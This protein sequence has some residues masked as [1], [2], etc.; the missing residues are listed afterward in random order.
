[1]FSKDK[2]NESN[3]KILYET[4]PNIIVYSKGI[5]IGMIL[6]GFLFS[7]YTT[8]IQYIG[9]MQVYLIE[10]SKLPMTRYF[11]IAIF[12]CIILVI[13]YIV[14]K[15]LAWTT[16]KYTITETRV[17]AEKGLLLHKKNYMPF[18]TIQDVDRSQS[19][20]GR[21]FSV[22]TITLYSAYDG[23]NIK[24]KDV[25][26]PKKIEDII[27][28]NIRGTHLKSRNL[29][30]EETGYSNSN[31]NPIRPNSD[32]K[33]HYRRMEDLDDLE[34]LDAKER[35]RNL[36]DIRKKAQQSRNNDYNKSNYDDS[37]YEGSDYESDYGSVNTYV[38]NERNRHYTSGAIR[39]SYQRN[40]KK[41]FAN[42]YEEF[43]QSNLEAQNQG[44]QGYASN[45]YSES[46]RG[47]GGSSSRSYED[48][49][50]RGYGGSSSRSYDGSS[51]G[52]AGPSHSYSESSSYGSSRP[53]D[54]SRGNY[55]KSRA[56]DG[57]SSNNHSR[58]APDRNINQGNLGND[59]GYDDHKS[60]GASVVINPSKDKK[61]SRGFNLF[62]NQDRYSDDYISD[63][64]FDSTIN[65]AMNNMEDNIKFKPSTSRKI[66]SVNNHNTNHNYDNM[67]YE[68]YSDDYDYSSSERVH[69]P[70]SERG[71]SPSSERGYSPSSEMGYSPSSE[72]VH[73][74]SSKRGYSPSSERGY[75]PSSERGYSPSSERGYSPSSERGYGEGYYSRRSKTNQRPYQNQESYDRG[76]DNQGSYSDRSYDNQNGHSNRAYNNQ[77]EYN[78]SRRDREPYH[79]SQRPYDSRNARVDSRANEYPHQES[80]YPERNDF[81]S[82][83]HDSRDFESNQYAGDRNRNPNYGN[84]RNNRN[85]RHSNNHKQYSNHSQNDYGSELKNVNNE[86]SVE[87]K[88]FEEENNDKNEDSVFAK[89]SRKFRKH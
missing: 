15:L 53:Y 55:S 75:S 76:Y 30:D 16:V 88:D 4:Q 26:S 43:H 81:D 32:E 29:Y 5:L 89:H 6:L 87:K 74:P 22:G 28:E 67:S 40:P 36:R 61:S 57:P 9:N 44:S 1:M 21:L 56:Y 7:L 78:S 12:V 46:S 50:S 27:F 23:N 52:F 19:L 25:S 47:Y 39:E 66:K 79:S 24:I 8:G 49:S 72:R 85:K 2:N 13:V 33:S 41:Y 3:E 63:E 20:F 73:S 77:R 11:A 62:D 17:I 83:Y 34:L 51:K 70:S 59:R 60:G 80:Y 42:N 82:N 64:E 14:F 31:F 18:N 35:K 69:S 71:Y 84:S 38:P 48:S 58:R 68:A 37:Y 65:Q 86:N 10:S 54:N 45:D